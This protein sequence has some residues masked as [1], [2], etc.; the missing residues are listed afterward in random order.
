VVRS[1]LILESLILVHHVI[2]YQTVLRLRILILYVWLHHGD[3]YRN[4]GSHHVYN[5]IDCVTTRK[6]S[7]G[8]EFSDQDF[9]QTE[10][11]YSLYYSSNNHNLSI[12]FTELR[13]F[14]ELICHSV[15][16]Q[17]MVFRTHLG[18]YEFL[19][20]SFEAITLTSLHEFDKPRTPL[21]SPNES[22]VL[23]TQA[24]PGVGFAAP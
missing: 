6:A 23:A 4:K 24:Q 10:P 16:I 9:C 13:Y 8:H 14:S 15:N 17:K 12:N 21:A 1:H 19:I 18:N 2:L 7:V 20:T 5:Q 22:H 3:Q 11:W